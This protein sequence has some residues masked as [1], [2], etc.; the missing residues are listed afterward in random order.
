MPQEPRRDQ[1]LAA[2][3]QPQLTD[4][5]ITSGPDVPGIIAELLATAGLPRDTTGYLD[6]YELIEPAR[7]VPHLGEAGF[8]VFGK[9]GVAVHL[10]LD[11]ATQAVVQVVCL[12][13][14]QPTITP[15]NTNLDLFRACMKA[16]VERFPFYSLDSV[17]NDPDVAEAVGAELRELFEGTDS[18]AGDGFWFELTYDVGMADWATE[19]VFGERGG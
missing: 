10:C 16:F 17:D 2:R 15:V 4:V 5:R 13:T 12:D 1:H 11:A 19:L 3:P 6:L 8:V 18:M 14:D 7:Y 9:A